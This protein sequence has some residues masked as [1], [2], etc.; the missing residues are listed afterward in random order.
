ML[1]GDQD[2]ATGTLPPAPPHLN[3]GT[4]QMAQRDCSLRLTIQNGGLPLVSS[5]LLGRIMLGPTRGAGRPVCSLENCP[6]ER[7]FPLGDASFAPLNKPLYLPPVQRSLYST[8]QTSRAAPRG[9][10]SI[11]T[12]CA[13]QPSAKAEGSSPTPKDTAAWLQLCLHCP[14]F[15][16]VPRPGGLARS[17][18]ALPAYFANRWTKSCK[19]AGPLS[20]RPGANLP[21][22]KSKITPLR[23]PDAPPVLGKDPVSLLQVRHSKRNPPDKKTRLCQE[24]QG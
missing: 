7:P 5:R 22:A 9:A 21:A 20:P 24:C 15:H 19:K 16:N 23:M 1:L 2:Q 13:L 17:C 12:A 10:A 11:N 18:P 3:P 6:A 8:H 14:F 4:F